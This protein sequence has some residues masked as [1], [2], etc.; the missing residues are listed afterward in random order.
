MKSIELSES[1]RF[2]VRTHGDS[3]RWISREIDR[4]GMWAREETRHVMDRLRPGCTFVDVGANIGWFALVASRIAGPTGR[5]IAIEPDPVNC[6]LLAGNVIAN[7]M[8]NVQILS[9]GASNKAG[10]ATL[11]KSPTNFGDHRMFASGDGRSEIQVTVDTLSRMI[12]G[13]IDLIKCDTQGHE[14][15]VFEGLADYFAA[16]YKRPALVF[17][18]WPNGLAASGRSVD[19]L[20][21]VL[22]GYGYEIPE[23]PWRHLER[24]PDFEAHTTMVIDP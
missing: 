19:A 24:S 21:D 15:H 23:T 18:L 7:G 9:M 12:A 20:F 3:D 5:V 2:V 10:T 1:I 17:E 16:G 13:D 14:C 6:N 22:R 8:R 11:R 4:N